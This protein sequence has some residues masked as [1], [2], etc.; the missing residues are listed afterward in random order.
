MLMMILLDLYMT[1]TQS[2]NAR[3]SSFASSIGFCK[4]L[5]MLP[6]IEQLFACIFSCSEAQG[7]NLSK[8]VLYEDASNKQLKEF[9]LVLSGCEI[10]INACSSLGK[11]LSDVSAA[12]RNFKNAFDWT[13]LIIIVGSN[14]LTKFYFTRL[15]IIRRVAGGPF[16]FCRDS[17]L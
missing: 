4:K 16:F 2:R 17:F 15:A 5:A 1:Q 9:V 3:R 13:V 6:D 8:V 10:I 11:D 7:R 14:C 12:L